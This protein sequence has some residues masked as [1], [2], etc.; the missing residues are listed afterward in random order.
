VTHDGVGAILSEDDDALRAASA[1]REPR[2]VAAKLPL[3][4]WV[5]AALGLDDRVEVCSPDLDVGEPSVR[6]V[7]LLKLNHDRFFEVRS[8]REPFDES[9]E[10][11][12]APRQPE[13][14]GRGHVVLVATQEVE[15]RL[16]R[17]TVEDEVRHG[18]PASG[19]TSRMASPPSVPGFPE[20]SYDLTAANPTA[21][22]GRS[23]PARL[24]GASV[25]GTLEF[26]EHGDT[27]LGIPC[28]NV[29]D[30]RPSA[31]ESEFA[32]IG[33]Q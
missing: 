4:R 2:L 19:A 7:V 28:D 33:R 21:S 25:A 22:E 26:R 32:D 10:Q 16:D 12:S 11:R 8:R 3:R 15:E 14:E 31:R 18:R 29:G 23:H 13:P 1:A 20:D 27:V 17:P 5:P 6:L 30:A 9:L 24:A